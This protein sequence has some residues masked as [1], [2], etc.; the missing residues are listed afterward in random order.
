MNIWSK[1]ITAVRGSIND[2]GESVVDARA[3]TILDQEIR[4]ADEEL[5]LARESLATMM[6]RQKMAEAAVKK[7]NGAIGEYEGYAVKSLE[8]GKEDLGLEVAEKIAN[9]EAERAVEE[10]QAA[11]YAASVTSLRKSVQQAEGN[12]KRLKQQVDTVKAMESVQKAQI[13]VAR[14]YGGSQAKLQTALDSLERIKKRQTETAAKLE[15]VNEL[16]REYGEYGDVDLMRKLEQ[17]GIVPA[18]QNAE[19]VLDRLRAKVKSKK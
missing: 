15:A 10:E 3:L 14:R 9:L 19:M 1:M 6:A 7:L 17:A 4:D 8:A 12:I 2:L 18:N 5:K 13:T 16:N 11:E